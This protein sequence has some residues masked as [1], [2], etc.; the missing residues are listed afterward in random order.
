M[1]GVA[2]KLVL[3]L[4]GSGGC[5]AGFLPSGLTYVWWRFGVPEFDDL[6]IDFTIHNDLSTKPGIYLQLYQGKIG[7]VG[8]YF[9]FQT[10][11]YDPALWKGRG[12][13]IVFSRWKTRD[14]SDARPISGG[15][16]QSSG[17][18]GDFIGIRRKYDWTSH[19]YRFRL[20]RIEDDER[21]T[22]YGLFIL[23]RDRGREDYVGSLRFPE[24]SG[25]RPLIKDGGGSWT[26]VYSGAGRPDDIPSWHVSIEGCYAERRKVRARQAVSDYSKV[27]NTDVFFDEKTRN[28]HM[29]M[30][31]GVK[32]AHTK[33]R[34]F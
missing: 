12:K 9:G 1:T 6:Q 31:R 13:G 18:E 23:D 20:T 32:R 21:G 29:K 19:K 14:L 3:L 17:H 15:W 28:V 27:P 25:K 4:L 10:D 24:S 33:G 22:W 7:D 11:V 2:A 34:L 30:G 8:F 26:E 5:S 16:V